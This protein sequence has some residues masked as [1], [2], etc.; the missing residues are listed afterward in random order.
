MPSKPPDFAIDAATLGRYA[1]SYSGRQRQRAALRGA[2][3]AK[4]VCMNC[5]PRRGR[6]GCRWTSCHLPSALRGRS[7]TSGSRSCGR[8]AERVRARL[9]RPSDELQSSAPDAPKEAPKEKT[10]RVLPTRRRDGARLPRPDARPAES[11]RPGVDWPSFRGPTASGVSD[12]F[13][14]AREVGRDQGR[15]RALE[16]AHPGARRLEP[17]RVGRPAVRHHGRQQRSERRLPPRA[18][19]RRRAVEGR[20]DALVARARASTRRRAACCGRSVA[21][22]GVPKTKRHPK[23]SQASRTPVTDGTHRRGVLRLGR[24]L[25]L[26]HGRQAALEARPGR[27]ERRLVLRPR[28]RVGRRQLADHLATT[29]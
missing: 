19:R 24:A 26:R 25:R 4:L 5:A 29:W 2:S 3:D 18:L 21:H 8:P 11:A 20:D 6:A 27:A 15:G 13:A 7:R 12:G 28:L 14:D 16:D 10:M 1:G 9:G 17:D 23:S 22:E